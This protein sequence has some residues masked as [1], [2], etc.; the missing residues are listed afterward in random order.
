MHVSWYQWIEIHCIV[1]PV[2]FDGGLS[3]SVL[4]N[5]QVF[6]KKLGFKTDQFSKSLNSEIFQTPSFE[7]Q[8][9]PLEKVSLFRSHFSCERNRQPTIKFDMDQ[10]MRFIYRLILQKSVFLE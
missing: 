9:I 7:G 4:R 6:T 10:E 3:M 5:G 1:L 2:K 8:I